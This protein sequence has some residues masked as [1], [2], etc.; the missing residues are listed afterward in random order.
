MYGDPSHDWVLLEFLTDLST[1]GFQQFIKYS[2]GFP[3]P[4]LIPAEVSAGWFVS[5]SCDFL[6]WPICVCNFRGS[7]LPC[8]L[9]CHMN[10]R[11]VVDF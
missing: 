11:R 8:D 4:A 1:L 9:T 7:H 10:L 2:L 3:T 6:Y 5:V